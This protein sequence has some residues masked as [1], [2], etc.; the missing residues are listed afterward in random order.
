MKIAII[1]D[2]LLTCGGSEQVFRYFLQAFPEAD[3]YTIAYN[4][5]SCLPEYKSYQINISFLN[6]VIRNHFTFRIMFPI[7]CL[8]MEH[9]D[10]SAYDLIVTSSATTAKYIKKFNCPHICYCYFPTR[11][12]WDFSKYFSEDTDLKAKVFKR[13]LDYFKKKDIAASQRVSHFIAISEV[14]RVQINN[15]YH[16]ESKVLS[17]PVEVDKFAAGATN[18][19]GD[20]FL[21]VSRL[22]KW[23]VLDFAIKAFNKLGLP[24]R[25]IGEG[26]E[27][28][29]LKKLANNNIEFLGRVDELQLIREYGLARAVIFTPEL[30][31]GLVPIEAN[32]AGT[33]VIALGKSGVLETMIPA[34]T[35]E[36][37][38]TAI[39]YYEQT[40]EALIAAIKMFEQTEFNQDKLIEHARHYDVPLFVKNLREM[41]MDVYSN[42]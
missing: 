9:W 1:Q 26:V 30:E 5:D 38:P 17:C 32:A 21:I 34:T 19:K 37:A 33:P 15:I 18:N 29:T 10:F 40:P 4:S 6:C 36:K 22:E 3:I 16:R 24:L 12:I 31:Y 39:F 14:T 7:S 20:H 13:F 42:Q 11:A 2:Q 27:E 28:V 35:T 23:K 41:A 25:I 8:V